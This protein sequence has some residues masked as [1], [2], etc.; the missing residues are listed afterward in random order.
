MGE[1]L[2][3]TFLLTRIKK[4]SKRAFKRLR[5]STSIEA[6]N[7]ASDGPSPTFLLSDNI[8]GCRLKPS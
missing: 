4:I 6:E 7:A 5:V 2:L 3:I 8:L 1:D